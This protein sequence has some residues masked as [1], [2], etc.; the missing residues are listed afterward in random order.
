VHDRAV[1][2]GVRPEEDHLRTEPAQAHERVGHALITDVPIGV[3][4]EAVAAQLVAHRTRGQQ[5]EVDATGGELL[6]KLEQ[7]AGVVLG[8]LDDE[9]GLVGTRRRRRCDRAADQHEPGHG[10]GVVADVLGEHLEF[11]MLGDARRGDGRVRGTRPVEQPQRAGHI[12]RR[13]KVRVRRKGLAQPAQ[14][15]RVGDRVGR[16]QRHV[17]E[18]AAGAAD[19][20][21]THRDEVFAHDAQ[22]RRRREGIL[23]GGDATVDRVLDRDH[24]CVGPPLDHVG[25]R[26]AHIAHGAPHVLARLR[27]LSEGGLREGSGGAEVA[28]G[29]ARGIGLGRVDRHGD[30]A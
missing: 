21:E 30:K 20:H 25:K 11:V 24:R 16:D 1:R 22:A 26:L 10:V 7:R 6:E 18:P 15:L 8:E 9:R 12:A 2:S 29:A 13:G 19:Q 4:H 27:H 5:R 28:V 14:A 23:R 3:D 17:L